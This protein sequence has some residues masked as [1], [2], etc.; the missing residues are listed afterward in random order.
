MKNWAR[1]TNANQCN[2]L[3]L[4]SFK[5]A[6]TQ[7]LSWPK[8]IEQRISQ[9]GLRHLFLKKD[10][11]THTKVFERE[12]EIFHQEALFEILNKNKK[13]RTYS[14]L[15]LSIGSEEYLSTVRDTKERIALTKFRLSNHDLM[16][17]KGRHRK[18]NRNTRFCPF[19]PT[20]IEDE[21]HFLLKCH[22]YDNLRVKLFEYV[23]EVLPDF[24]PHPNE[25]FLFWF[26]LQCPAIIH[27]TANFISLAGELRYF[28]MRNFKNYT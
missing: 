16:I 14:S 13:L 1:I 23:K 9:I 19:C 17:E 4:K 3:V 12:K 25:K 11:N 28:I 21:T 6:V 26:L 20:K 10:K 7:N 8:C 27:H 2:D 24:F 22:M 15:K 5:N 18:M